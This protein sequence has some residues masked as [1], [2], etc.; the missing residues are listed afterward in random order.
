MI[1]IFQISIPKTGVWI[2]DMH[3]RSP[4]VAENSEHTV[5]EC[6]RDKMQIVG[7]ATENNHACK[8]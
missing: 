7:W 1:E 2:W 5:T 3:F 4:E 8:A 6:K